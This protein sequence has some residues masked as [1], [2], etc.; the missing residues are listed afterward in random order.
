MAQTPAKHAAAERPRAVTRSR[1]ARV[2][3]PTL[4]GRALSGRHPDRQSRATSRCGRWR[5]WPPPTSS[6]ARTPASPASSP[7]TTASPRRSRPITSTMPPRRGRSCWRGSPH[8]QAV[9]LVSDAGTPLISDPGYK[10]VRAAQRGRPRGHRAARRLGGARR[11]RRR[12]PADRPLLLRRLPAAQAGGAAEAHRRARR[13]SRR[14]W[15]CSKAARA[16]PRR[17]PISPQGSGR[18]RPRSAAS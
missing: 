2:E 13:A 12:R 16:S 3:A 5:R 18:A 9:A 10:L 14:R 15:C 7:S 6:P 4:R 11:A 1:G 8:G 17:S